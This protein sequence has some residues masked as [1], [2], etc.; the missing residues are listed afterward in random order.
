MNRG[1]QGQRGREDREANDSRHQ[2][3]LADSAGAVP[4]AGGRTAQIIDAGQE[5]HA[6]PTAEPDASARGG[7]RRSGRTRVMNRPSPSATAV[8]A[9]MPRSHNGIAIPAKSP[10]WPCAGTPFDPGPPNPIATPITAIHSKP[11]VP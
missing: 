5:T 9:T 8:S 2:C 3:Q 4:H 6:V 7:G 10:Q 1:Q 11:A